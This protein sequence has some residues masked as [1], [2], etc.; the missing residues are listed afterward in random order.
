MPEATLTLW[1][2]S[3]QRI[4]CRLGSLSLSKKKVL[5][6]CTL[7]SK[8]AEI[9]KGQIQSRRAPI[10]MAK[11]KKPSWLFEESAWK[12]QDTKSQ[13]VGGGTGGLNRGE[14]HTRTNKHPVHRSDGWERICHNIA[15]QTAERM[16]DYPL[17]VSNDNW[18]SETVNLQWKNITPEVWAGHFPM[19]WQSGMWEASPPFPHFFPCTHIPV[20]HFVFV[21]S[22]TEYNLHLHSQVI[23]RQE[24]KLQSAMMETRQWVDCPN[25]GVKMVRLKQPQATLNRPLNPHAGQPG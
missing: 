1:L 21:F 9:H 4:V 3:W 14:I 2:P 10:T 7:R 16:A 20:S 15:L 25:F 22:R 18:R 5:K 23:W 11:K 8:Q 13:V 12:R 17:H 24:S 19:V 6:R